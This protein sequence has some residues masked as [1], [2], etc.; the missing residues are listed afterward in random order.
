LE[1]EMKA[2]LIRLRQQYLG[3]G[4]DRKRIVQVLT[5]SLSSFLVLLRAALR[6]YRAEVPAKKIDAVDALAEH[7]AFDTGVFR[8]VEALKRGE[9]PV[10]EVNGDALFDRYLRA[11]ED[12]ADAVD[13]HI[14]KRREGTT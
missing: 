12:I 10:R 13:R 8:A 9:L 1:Y 3:T 4:R 5:G 11:L 14:A 6:L 2:R 7:I